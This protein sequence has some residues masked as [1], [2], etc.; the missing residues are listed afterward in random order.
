MFHLHFITQEKD[1]EE[2]L[3]ENLSLHNLSFERPKGKFIP[4]IVCLLTPAK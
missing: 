1:V 2:P 3:P 4:N